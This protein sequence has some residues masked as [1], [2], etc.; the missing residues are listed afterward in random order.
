[1]SVI[2]SVEKLWDENELLI[3]KV[4][5]VSV[6]LAQGRLLLQCVVI[7]SENAGHVTSEPRKTFFLRVR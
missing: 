3:A 7:G 5:W 4:A 2:G 1:M 6:S